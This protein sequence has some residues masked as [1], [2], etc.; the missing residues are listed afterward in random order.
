[1]SKYKK[2]SIEI[3]HTFDLV[4]KLMRLFFHKLLISH[5]FFTFEKNIF[6]NVKTFNIVW[7]SDKLSPPPLSMKTLMLITLHFV[8]KYFMKIWGNSTK[9]L[10]SKIGLHDKDVLYFDKVCF[11][12]KTGFVFTSKLVLPLLQPLQR[13]LYTSQWTERSKV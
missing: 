11:R 10:K 1:M 8:Q 7:I 12:A 5:T 6:H 3:R 2:I 9:I 13:P 4:T